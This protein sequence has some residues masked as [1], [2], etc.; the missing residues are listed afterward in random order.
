MAQVKTGWFKQSI[1]HSNAKRLGHAGGKYKGE[2]VKVISARRYEQFYIIEKKDGSRELVGGFE[3]GKPFYKEH[4]NI[5]HPRYKKE[6][7]VGGLG[8]NKTDTSF[9]KTQLEKGIKVEREHTNNPKI[10]KEIAKDHLTEDK[11]YYKK[12]AKIEK[13]VKL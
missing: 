2:Q 1:R 8:D 7:I 5:M 13:K 4:G 9:N 3:L 12:L 10:A 6:S 11:E